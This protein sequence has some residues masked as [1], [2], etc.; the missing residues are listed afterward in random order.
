MAGS[1]DELSRTIGHLENAIENVQKAQDQA[2]TY[3]QETR[4]EVAEIKHLLHQAK[5][6][7]RVL[8]IMGS[9]VGGVAGFGLNLLIK[10]KGG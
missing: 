1:I 7:W 8:V 4:K 5:G 2:K 3:N 9:I 10:L 6:G